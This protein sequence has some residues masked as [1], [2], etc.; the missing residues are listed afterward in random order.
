MGKNYTLI[1]LFSNY[2]ENEIITND[3]ND[4]SL[5]DFDEILN[6][7]ERNAKKVPDRIVDNIINFAKN[8]S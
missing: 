5:K 7:L 6:F 3:L 8:Y 1:Y 4:I 2:E